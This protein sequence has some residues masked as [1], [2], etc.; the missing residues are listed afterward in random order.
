[1]SG[2][3]RPRVAMSQLQRD[4]VEARLRENTKHEDIKNEV[5]CSLQQVRQMSSKFK[6][7]GT[8]TVPSVRK[9]GRPRELNAG[10][11][12]VQLQ[13]RP[14]YFLFIRRHVLI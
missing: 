1:M 4:I 10:H 5:G 7:F 2:P 3:V 14:F 11:S 12:Q 9:R 8:V 13:W 6:H